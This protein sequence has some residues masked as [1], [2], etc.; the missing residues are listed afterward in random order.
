MLSANLRRIA[1]F[2][3]ALSLRARFP[4][5]AKWTSSVQWSRFS[6]P[7]ACDLQEPFG[8]HVFGQEIMAHERRVGAMATPASA[9]GDPA[10]RNDAGK[11]VNR[12][13]A[14]IAHDRRSSRFAPVV[15]GQFD[16]LGAAAFAGARKLLRDGLEQGPA[17]G[18]DRQDIVAA[19]IE[20]CRGKC[21]MAMERI[22]CND[23]ALETQQI[24]DFQSTRGLVATWR[25]P[26][27]QSHA[28]LHRKDVDQLQWRGLS[29]AFVGATHSLAVDRH[30]S[31]EFEAVGLRKRRHEATECGF[32]RTR[33]EQT[34]YAAE[35]VM[36]LG[37]PCPKRRTSRSNP[38]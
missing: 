8:R 20:H 6:I 27:R 25:F 30:H 10:H 17:I 15:T 21:A 34:E 9:R 3:G 18:L 35:R 1:R 2:S 12:N 5:S 16:P 11:I 23:A 38:S 31:R 26:L 28:G 24:D 14:G 7:T 36:W 13:E 19:P 37:I 4:S 22:G 33:I 29:A 32:E